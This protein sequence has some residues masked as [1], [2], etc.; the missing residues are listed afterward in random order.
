MTRRSSPNYRNY[1]F[2]DGR[3]AKHNLV[4]AIQKVEKLAAEQGR[5][6]ED[7]VAVVDTQGSKLSMGMETTT[8]LTRARGY[9]NAFWSLQ[10][11][12]PL[13]VHEMLRLQGFD[14]S[15]VKVPLA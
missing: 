11:G 12:R 9:S 4:K 8:T 10:H 3:T 1:P 14:A 7:Y 5:H 15:V 2:P 6:P 13:S